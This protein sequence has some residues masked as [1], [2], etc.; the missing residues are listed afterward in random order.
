MKAKKI[1]TYLLCAAMLTPAMMFGS[2]VEAEGKTENGLY[3]NKTATYNEGTDDYTITLEAYATG[4]KT[5]TSEYK[6]VPTDIILVLDQSG[7][8]KDDIGTVYFSKYEN[9]N[10]KNSSLYNQRHNGGNANLW[11]EV[12]KN[13][14]VSVSVT[15]TNKY[16]ELLDTYVNY[17]TSWGSVTSSCYWY[18]RENLYEKVG[19]EYKKVTLTR[20][21]KWY[22]NYTYTY[23]FADGTTVTSEGNNSTP[24]FGTHGSLWT[25]AA[26]G[27]ET[28]Y[29]YTYTLND[30]TVTIG[31]ST[32][33]SE[34][35]TQKVLYKRNVSTGGGGS[36]L[37][38]LKTAVTNFADAVAKKAAGA[39]GVLGT[40]D[41][42]NHRIAM[43]GFASSTGYENYNRIEYENTELFVGKSTYSYGD[44]AKS[45]YKNALQSMNTDAGY[46]NIIASKDS[47]DAYGGTFTNLGIEMANGIFSE[48]EIKNNEKRNRVVI[49]FTDGY[50]GTG[51]S[52]SQSVANSAVEEAYKTKNTYNATVYTVGVFSGANGTPVEDVSSVSNV[53][54]FMHLLSSNY[55]NAQ[56]YSD[57]SKYGTKTY[58]ANGKSYYLS[59][60]DSESLNNIFQQIS[61]QIEDESASTTLDETAVIKDIISPQFQL[62]TGTSNITLETYDCIG[63]NGTEY[64]WSDTPGDSSGITANTGKTE[65]GEDTVSVTGFDFAD[66]YVGTINDQGTISYRGK[67]LVITFTV[68][69]RDGFLGGND[70]PT[71]TNANVYEDATSENPVATFPRPT[72]N[73]PI[74]DVTVTA[75]DKNVYLLGNLTAEQIKSGATV[76]CGD[77][78][79]DLAADN[80]G[81]ESWQTEYVDIGDLKIVDAD[82]NE[83]NISD[84]QN[85]KD[86]TTYRLELTIS[87]KT[88]GSS[89]TE[90]TVATAR[91]NAADNGIGKINV[92]KPELTFKDSVVY[93]GNPVPT[94][95][96]TANYVST[97]TVWKHKNTDG[98]ETTASAEMGTVPTL[99]FAYTPDSSQIKDGKINAN[100]D[101]IGVEVKVSVN[102]TEIDDAYVLKFNHE[103]G[104]SE[105]SSCPELTD[106]Y[107]FWLHILSTEL[108]ITKT[109]DKKI[110]AQSFLFTVTLGDGTTFKVVID[111]D[112]FTENTATI[113]IKD[114]KVGQSCTVT[115]DT[116]WSWRYEV[117]GKSEVKQTLSANK[118][119]NN[120]EFKNKLTTE[121]WLGEETFVE[122]YWTDQN[123]IM[124]NPTFPLTIVNSKKD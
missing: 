33:A 99:T 29:T 62:P 123:T 112:E 65:D 28:V 114:L 116:S 32:G 70:V 15:K 110:E 36:K 30:D 73:V 63:K 10:T 88:D 51:D 117:D 111:A 81:L 58:P 100:S 22:D 80:Y 45:Q 53:N 43:V 19:D 31:T 40:D 119:E 3:V 105:I 94:D 44:K 109:V 9:N 69:K 34:K 49:V 68:K 87:P 108:T 42:V 92:F 35:F 101:K 50:P 25:P 6:D 4:E 107:K 86:D 106:S 18:Y 17:D 74:Q 41:D 115:E 26:D 104:V 84:Y 82:G 52:V 77:V 98:S 91:K 37:D 103:C 118:N 113:T 38:A 102:G 48:N 64:R 24:D 47:L 39:D 11:Y 16:T 71:N 121:E 97:S 78:E 122:N 72:V 61:E 14:Y 12:S 13:N 120:F 23:T 93:N 96:D 83:V 56:S 66:N 90:G 20:E 60:S 59:A 1:L 79:L 5:I 76:K 124:Q 67:K 55:K 95:F 89:T 57:S 2:T 54:R 8:M 46:N 21:G 7:S 75:E 27:N 85:L